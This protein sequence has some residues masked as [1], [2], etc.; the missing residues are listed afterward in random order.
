MKE[1]EKEKENSSLYR[2]IDRMEVY[3]ESFETKNNDSY[4]MYSQSLSSIKGLKETT[5]V[6]QLRRFDL[7]L[8]IDVLGDLI[9]TQLDK[10]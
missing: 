6:E 2:L 1:L 8:L 3:I 10:N 5:S 4:I 7:F 9:E